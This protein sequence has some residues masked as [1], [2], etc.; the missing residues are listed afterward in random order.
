MTIDANTD[1]QM[2]LR[3]GYNSLVPDLD[4]WRQFDRDL[5]ISQQLLKKTGIKASADSNGLLNHWRAMMQKLLLKPVRV[6]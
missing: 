1:K 4:K 2:P 6:K 3:A 5:L